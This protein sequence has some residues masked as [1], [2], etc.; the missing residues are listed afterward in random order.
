MHQKQAAFTAACFFIHPFYP[1]LI[2]TKLRFSLFF[3][4]YY[5]FRKKYATIIL[6]YRIPSTGN[7]VLENQQGWL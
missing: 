5:I 3:P 6:Q 1:D 7:V 2:L 4:G